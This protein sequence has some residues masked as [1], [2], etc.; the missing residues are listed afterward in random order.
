MDNKLF[1]SFVNNSIM[2][3]ACH[4]IVCDKD[5]VPVDYEFV[6]FNPAYERHTSVKSGTVI[7]KRVSEIIPNIKTSKYDW[8]STYGNIALNGGEK[9]FDLFYD[10]VYYYKDFKVYSPQKYY[11][12]TMFFDI[13]PFD[14]QEEAFMSRELDINDLLDISEVQSA[15]DAFNKITNLAMAIGN[16]KGELVVQA[17][18]QDICKN[19]HRKCEKSCENCAQSDIRLFQ[20]VIS[21]EYL[22]YKCLNNMWDISTPIIIDGKVVGALYLGQFIYDDDVLDYDVFRKQAKLFGY[23]EDKYM[24]ALES[25]PQF[26]HQAIENIM[27]FYSKFANIVALLGYKNLSIQAAKTKQEILIASLMESEN[28]FASTINSIPDAILIF[29]QECIIQFANETIFDISGKHAS[30][31]TG[32]SA[33]EI[34]ETDQVPSF[35]PALKKTLDTRLTQSLNIEY[36][37]SENTCKNYS[38][39]FIPL[40]G[41]GK[42][43][44]IIGVIHDYTKQ[45]QTEEEKTYHEH[46]IREMGKV[47][48]IGGWEFDAGSGKGSWTEEVAKIHELDPKDAT[49]IELGTS[50]YTSESKIRIEQAIKEAIESAKPY[51]VELELITKS[52]VNKWVRTIGQLMKLHS[53]KGAEILENA[54]EYKGIADYILSH[55]ERYN[56]SGY[57]AGLKGEEIPLVSRIIAVADS[58]DAMTNDR[59]YREKMSSDDAANELIKCSGILY[60]PNIVSV[61]IDKVLPENSFSKVGA[62]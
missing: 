7:G 11:F 13:I 55:H 29:D 34:W 32:K 12:I 6:D 10:S 30:Y 21:G 35:F 47:A 37:S 52:G 62:G 38:I 61:F 24:K 23:D 49:N 28:R 51:D 59:S 50:F 16:K 60:D 42:N 3:V 31:L 39:T 54:I 53:A 9:E 18:F 15:V 17:G 36:Y 33:E 1:A 4:K 5:G 41:V 46:L 19:F 40:T 20:S 43:I 44:E 56:G 26:S 48:K 45:K 58:Y 2:P 22:Q 14:D 8:I 27:N 25:V 57:P